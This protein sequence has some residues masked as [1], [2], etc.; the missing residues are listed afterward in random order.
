M[1]S[2]FFLNIN[3]TTSFFSQALSASDVWSFGVLLWEVFSF[4]AEPYPDKTDHEA[5]DEVIFCV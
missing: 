4:G 2:C 3:F 1:Y 5:R